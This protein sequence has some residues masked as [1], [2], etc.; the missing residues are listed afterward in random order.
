MTYYEI[1]HKCPQ[2]GSEKL[3]WLGW[4]DGDLNPITDMLTLD[5][6]PTPLPK[7][8]AYCIQCSIFVTPIDSRRI[9]E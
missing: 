3:N 6:L 1:V 4:M 5:F 8:Q 2:C 9:S 7:N